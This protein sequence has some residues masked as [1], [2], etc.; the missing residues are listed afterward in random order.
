MQHVKTRCNIACTNALNIN[1]LVSIYTEINL[2]FN[3]LFLAVK[4]R[5][6]DNDELTD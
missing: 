1:K 5:K 2:Y 4:Q 6:Y 3:D